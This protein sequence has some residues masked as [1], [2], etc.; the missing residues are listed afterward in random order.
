MN[1]WKNFLLKKKTLVLIVFAA[2]ACIFFIISF[3]QIT[4]SQN[5]HLLISTKDAEWIRFREPTNLKAKPK[6]ILTT[7]FKAY[8]ET[9]D[10]IN[11]AILAVRVMKTAAIYLNGKKISEVNADLSNWK[12]EYN[13]D[14][15]PWLENGRHE[16]RIIVKSHDSHPALIAHCREIGLY[17]SEHWQASSDGVAWTSALSVHQLILPEIT[18]NFTRADLALFSQLKFFIPI[19]LL[20]SLLAYFSRNRSVSDLTPF[21]ALA[22]PSRFR[23][24]LLTAMTIL[25]INNIGKIPLNVG[26]DIHGHIDYINHIIAYAHLPSASSGWQTFQAPLFYIIA[27]LWSKILLIF[28]PPDDAM[29]YLRAIPLLC[30]IA[31]VEICYRTMKMLYPEN[32][33]VQIIG[34][35]VGGLLPMNIYM[36]QVVGNE[37]LA[38]M[39]MSIAIYFVLKILRHQTVAPVRVFIGAG[40]FLG[41]AIL[42]KVTAVLLVAPILTLIILTAW[43][44]NTYLMAQVN[45]QIFCRA[46]GMLV[47]AFIVCIWYF[48]RNWLAA[49]TLIAINTSIFW[50]QDPGY[51]TFNQVFSFGTSLFYPV[52]CSIAGFWD[53]LYSTMWMDGLLSAYNQPPWNYN[54]MLSGAWL[55]LL[56]AFAITLGLASMIFRPVR[57]LKQGSFIAAAGVLIFLAAIF[58]VFLTNPALSSAKATYALGLLP[59][60]ATLCAEGFRIMTAKKIIR[61]ALYGLIACWAVASYCAYFVL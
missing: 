32:P 13:Y 3:R 5:I 52:Y 51:R 61:P 7:H 48:I 10:Q 16:L 53:S 58:Y 40:F 15:G 59:C 56:P 19:F 55:S 23:L 2:V 9:T 27:A 37:P 33:S 4:G 45:R 8:F 1:A 46:L 34:T 39:F 44:K 49:N 21:A 35:C 20:F 17:T 47:A 38:A 60:L 50:W 22:T 30:G 28:M 14:L 36:S 12:K 6:Q 18:Y 41:L 26:M 31:Q 25:A 43:I 54:F 42:T 29:V 57:Y 11:K 24:I